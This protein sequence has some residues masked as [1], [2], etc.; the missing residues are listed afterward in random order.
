VVVLD[1]DDSAGFES[2]FASPFESFFV[3]LFDSLLG[4]DEPDL[5]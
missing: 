3:S 5:A 4:D 1:V 2:L